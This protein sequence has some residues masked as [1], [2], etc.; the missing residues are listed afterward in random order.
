MIVTLLL[1]PSLADTMIELENGL[2]LIE[3]SIIAGALTVLFTFV[4]FC[5]TKFVKP[6]VKASKAFNQ[7]WDDAGE[8][9]TIRRNLDNIAEAI[10]PTNGD[11]RTLSAR[12]DDIKTFAIN[13]KA[14]ADEAKATAKETQDR[15]LSYQHDEMI[16]RRER[17]RIAD[18]RERT[19]Q[20]RFERMEQTQVDMNSRQTELSHRQT[21]METILRRILLK[22]EMEAD[23][24]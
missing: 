9:Q 4:G 13:A 2:N 16:E 22:L 8:I 7:R 6:V 3:L 20:G 11:K 21:R 18:D 15:F 17:I 10:K 1:G 19:S 12:L 23:D 5:Y 14:S 24:G